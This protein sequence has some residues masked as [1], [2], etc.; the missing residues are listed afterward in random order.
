MAATQP[1]KNRQEIGD[2]S[3]TLDALDARNNPEAANAR[4]AERFQYRMQNITM[5]ITGVPG[6]APTFSG[7]A[8]NISDHGISLIVNQF[9]YPGTKCR[10]TLV[11][12]INHK[13]VQSGTIVRCRYL[14]GSARLHEIGIKFDEPIN[15]SM[16]HSGTT[17]TRVILLCEEM[18]T[19][20][21]KVLIGKEYAN[22]VPHDAEDDI[23]AKLN[24]DA[25]DVVICEK[26]HDDLKTFATDI[27]GKGLFTPLVAVVADADDEAKKE[28]TDAGF[29]GI[30][31]FPLTRAAIR[32][33]IAEFRVEPMTS[34]LIFD[35]ELLEFIDA[36]VERVPTFIDEVRE[37]VMSEEVDKLKASLK[38]L[39]F[40]ATS[41]G[42]EQIGDEIKEF[43][44]LLDEGSPDL[45]TIRGHVTRALRLCG[46]AT[47]ASCKG[48]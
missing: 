36:F 2:I 12:V 13:V 46:R 9:M 1:P 45:P 17:P 44:P 29:D 24:S 6:A 16:F 18:T 19:K 28:L 23:V 7:H 14:T 8:R 21:L 35:N 38:S 15:V 47:G 31:E 42:F 37:A 3:E 20:T 33:A 41:A 32:N 10:V 34:N 48:G 39:M 40:A 11:S 27:R 4:Q 25:A 5:E 22:I 43:L 26:P 30:V